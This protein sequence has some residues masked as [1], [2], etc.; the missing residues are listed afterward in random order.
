M[1]LERQTS[2]SLIENWDSV[3]M[4]LLIF[5]LSARSM[6]KSVPL[7]EMG[8]EGKTV[9]SK[10]DIQNGMGEEEEQRGQKGRERGHE[11]KVEGKMGLKDSYYWD[12]KCLEK[13]YHF[14]QLDAAYVMRITLNLWLL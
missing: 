12:I 9:G 1:C 3:E 7:W 5:T 10:E 2:K 13:S 8:E 6:R 4:M 14:L 11:T